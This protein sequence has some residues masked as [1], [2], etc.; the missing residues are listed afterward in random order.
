M[1]PKTGEQ[2][3][4]FGTFRRQDCVVYG[5]EYLLGDK[6]QRWSAY[7]V[8]RAYKKVG[9]LPLLSCQTAK[10]RAVA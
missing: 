3:S 1:V 6:G 7:Q 2:I 9:Y 8:N 10:L 5:S 4:A